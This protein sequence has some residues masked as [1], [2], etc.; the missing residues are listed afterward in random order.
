[1]RNILKAVAAVTIGVLA[2]LA[3]PAPAVHAQSNSLPQVLALQPAKYISNQYTGI[4]TTP[5]LYIKYVGTAATNSVAQTLNTSIVF[6]EAGAAPASGTLK[7]PTGGTLGTIDVTNAAC[8]TLGEVV[9]VINSSVSA[10]GTHDWQA[11]IGAA[12]RSDTSQKLLNLSATNAAGPAGVAIYDS[13]ATSAQPSDIPF[14]GPDSLGIQYWLAPGAKRITK[15][16][17]SETDTVLQYGHFN[18]TNAGTVG[19]ISVYCVVEQY[20]AIGNSSETASVIYLEAGAAT[21]VTGKIDEFLNAGGLH[22]Q[23]GK[24]FVREAVSGA[25]TSAETLLVT[26]YQTKFKPQTPFAAIP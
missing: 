10:A 3:G 2:F 19:N 17:F 15:N 21:T 4:T 18:V 6:Q 26:G 16:P 5:W 11:V 13:I 25:A 14:W 20:N 8:D 23:G 1:M 9:D 22:C 24:M 7:C 12:L